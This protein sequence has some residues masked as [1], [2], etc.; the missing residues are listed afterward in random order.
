MNRIVTFI[1]AW[2][3]S[4]AA[5]GAININ[6]ATKEELNALPGIGPVKAQAIL[7]YRNANGPFKMP[8]D[9]MKVN[10]IKEREFTKMRDLISTEPSVRPGG[11]PKGPPCPKGKDD[12]K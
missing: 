2:L 5:F 8:E 9:L 10:G 11:C 12:R 7:D 6:T 1:V 4:V 3:F